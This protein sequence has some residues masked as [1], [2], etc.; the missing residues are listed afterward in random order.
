MIDKY[1]LYY[2][3]LLITFWVSMTFG[4]VSEEILPFLQGLKPTVRLLV[5]AVVLVLGLTLIENRRDKIIAWTFLA[6]AVVSSLIINRLGFVNTFNGARDFFGLVFVI[7]IFRY[8]FNHERGGKEFTDFFDRQLYIF[9]W[10]QPFCVLEQFFRYGAGD[11]VGGSLGNFASGLISL[12]IYFTSFYLMTRRW[13]DKLSYIKNIS[14][15][16]VLVILL[17]PTFLNETK[18]SFILLLLYFVL[19]FKLEWRSVRKLLMAVPLILVAMVGLGALYLNVTDQDADEL[20][21]LEFYNEYL[22]GEDPEFLIDLAIR[23]QDGEV[24]TDNMWVTDLPRFTRIVQAP[25]AVRHSK[26]GLIF[27]AGL[28]HFKGGQTLEKTQFGRE[29]GWLIEGSRTWLFILLIEFGVIGVLWFAVSFGLMV[30]DR[31]DDYLYSKNVRIYAV[32]IMTI[33]MV[34]TEVVREFNFC[35]IFL[36]IILYATLNIPSRDDYGVSPTYD[37]NVRQ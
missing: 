35:A 5:D 24:E 14:D 27:G 26:G 6:M 21:S 25:E 7:P 36:Y 13:D 17:F 28:G 12:L 29:Y 11:H 4:F 8:F 31:R 32:A 9:L 20:T 22:V 10:L 37:S 23:V 30:K 33:I 2:R 19:L 1:T 3:T 34:Y 15:N 16:R 18:V